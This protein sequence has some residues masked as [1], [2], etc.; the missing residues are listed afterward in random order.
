MN[1]N[2]NYMTGFWQFMSLADI[3]FLNSI[4]VL[5]N[6]NIYCFV[7][8]LQWVLAHLNSKIYQMVSLGIDLMYNVESHF[9]VIRLVVP[10]LPQ[11]TILK[12]ISR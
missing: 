8:N 4:Q 9:S 6:N 3:P 1:N 11:I 5:V 7:D 12:T 10:A 2:C